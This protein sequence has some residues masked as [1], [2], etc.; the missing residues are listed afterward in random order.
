MEKDN[1]S[2]QQTFITYNDILNG[3]KRLNLPENPILLVHSSMKSFGYVEGGPETVIKALI[4]TCGNK[5]TLVM[6][7]LTFASINEA[8]PFFD[9]SE[10]PSGTGLITEVFRKMPDARRS[11]H[12]FS[13]AAALGEKAEY[14]T[15]YH[16]DTPCGP[17]TPYQKI[18]ELEGYVLF[19][20]AGFGSNTLFHVAEEYVNPPY[21]RY[22]TIKNAK[23]NDL[24]GNTYFRDIRRY[25][26]Y[27][28]GI[29]RRLDRMKDI[30]ENENVLTRTV[31]GNSNI[32]LI[33][34]EDNFRISCNL[35][36]NN[37]RYI[38]ENE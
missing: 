15:S 11:L 7:T 19:I 14:I 16:D 37:Y 2:T 29:I 38:L 35:L 3:L 20:G 21:M 30:F 23:I 13:S 26:C 27:Q 8:E 33:R 34:A 18:I 4:D 5:G 25:D 10:T 12:L 9:A 28:T 24:E 22:K 6:P 31:I 36:G 32:T 17:G 1:S